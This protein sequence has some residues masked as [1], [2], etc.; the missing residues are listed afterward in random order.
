MSLPKIY[1]TKTPTRTYNPN[2]TQQYIIGR[3]LSVSNSSGSYTDVYDLTFACSLI[4]FAVE[5]SGSQNGDYYGVS[6]SDWI[7]S[8]SIYCKGVPQIFNLEIGRNISSGSSVI[9]NFYNSTNTEKVV[10]VDYYFIR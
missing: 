3:Q 7:L 2:L 9:L 6:G 1:W 8:E 4:R 5:S 10:W